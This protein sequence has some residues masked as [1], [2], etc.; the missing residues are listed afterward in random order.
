MRPDEREVA[1]LTC[2]AVLAALSDLHD[3]GI[4]PDL[5]RR[6][7][8]HAAACRQCESFGAGFAALLEAFRRRLADPEPVDPAV[9]ARLR[10]ILGW[11]PGR[12][13]PR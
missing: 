10:A 13:G 2:S 4:E 9:L 11:T 8:A 1:G 3:G 6:I 7:E 12:A 5:A